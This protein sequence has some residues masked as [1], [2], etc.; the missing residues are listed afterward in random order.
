M[1]L[2]RSRVLRFF[3]FVKPT[4]SNIASRADLEAI[5]QKRLL[6]E[7]VDHNSQTLQQASFSTNAQSLLKLSPAAVK[8]L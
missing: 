8:D 7:V 2:L 6:R 5:L 4:L 3:H 1:I